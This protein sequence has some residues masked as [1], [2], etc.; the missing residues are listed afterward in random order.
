MSDLPAKISIERDRLQDLLLA[1]AMT[2][3]NDA[4]PKRDRRFAVAARNI[5]LIGDTLDQVDDAVWVDVAMLD[6]ASE[7]ALSSL[8]AA[9]LLSIAFDLPPVGSGP[10][11][12]DEFA[13]MIE[14]ARVRLQ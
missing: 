12:F 7:D 6:V 5:R 8:I 14:T 3:V 4:E 9:R 10:F 13:T 2:R 1:V 11:F